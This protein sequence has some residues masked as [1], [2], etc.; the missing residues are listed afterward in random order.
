MTLIDC[1]VHPMLKHINEV[2]P[3]VAER[4]RGRIEEYSASA[5]ARPGDRYPYPGGNAMSLS[6]RTDGG[7]MP[8]TDP[9][10]TATD[11]FDGFGVTTGLLIALQASFTAAW[12]DHS[13]S[14]V[15]VRGMNDYFLQQWC[16]VDPRYRLALAVASWNPQF[17]A[18][19]IR[20]H[21]DNPA[22]AAVWVPLLN[23]LLGDRHYYPIFDAA[24]ECGLPIVL[25]PSSGDGSHPGLPSYA[26]LHNTYAG[27][28]CAFPQVAH[29]NLVSL[30]FDGV[31]E[32]F[33]DIQFA[34]I[35]FGFTW[36][37][38]AL[39]RMDDNWRGFRY[40]VPW[41][42]RKPSEYVWDRIRF[43]TQPLDDA[44][45]LSNLRAIV[46][47]MEGDRTLMFASD[48]AHY[49]NDDPAYVI[50]AMNPEIRDAVSYETAQAFFGERF[51]S[52][53]AKEAQVA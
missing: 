35:E 39:W 16:E 23:R 37:P 49:D 43:T 40:S 19:E 30:V 8:A 45:N 50:R 26:G 44:G 6:A 17:A 42:K 28:V 12:P 15:A 5:A 14:N 10:I 34:F 31:L 51:E 25:H 36:V 18:E 24:Q 41:V 22:V 52:G 48:Y 9:T 11:L 4:W 32:A 2:Q 7:P 13:V 21:G 20:R 53:I 27:R 47:M 38:T 46:E 1:D 29:S 3:L 33:P